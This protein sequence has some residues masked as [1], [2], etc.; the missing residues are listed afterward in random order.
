MKEGGATIVLRLQCME[1]TNTGR[2]DSKLLNRSP[3]NTVFLIQDV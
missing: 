1:E 3:M 2:C